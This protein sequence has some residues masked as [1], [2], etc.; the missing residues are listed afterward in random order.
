MI[1][2]K[3]KLKNFKNFTQKEVKLDKL[4]FIRGSNGSGKT[5]IALHSLLFA[6]YGYAVADSLKSL[7]TRNIA[8]S[9]KVEVELD[10]SDHTYKIVR[11]YPTKLIIYEDGKE[12]EFV[13]NTEAQEY[14]NELVGDRINFQKFRIIDAYTKETNFLEEGQTTI[15]RILFNNSDEIFNNIRNKLLQIKHEREIFCKDKAVIYTH[16]PSE[17]RLQ[18]ISSKLD[19]INLQKSKL[20]STIRSIESDAYSITRT[21]G[22]LE[23]E[24]ENLKRKRDKLLENKKCYACN[25]A[26]SESL[27]KGLLTEIG[28]EVKSINTMLQTKLSEQQNLKE[29]IASQKEIKEKLIPKTQKLLDYKVKLEGRLKQKAYKYTEKDILIVKR[30]ISEVDRLSTYYL[31]ESIKILE[32]IINSVLEKI[33]FNVRFTVSDKNKFTITLQKEGIEYK[34]KDLSTGQKLILQIGFKLALLLERGEDGVVIA[35]EGMSSLDEN[36]LN[37][38]IE[39]FKQFPF[40]LLFVLHRMQTKI[41]PIC[42]KKFDE[43]FKKCPECNIDLISLLENIQTIDLDKNEK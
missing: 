34:Y 43:A 5:T 3:I 10:H 23:A 1:I 15:K 9:C 25:Q 22:K 37:H 32:P 33:Q 29:I 14:I 4:V 39:L 6:L 30:A 18:L 16:Y 36:N 13:S 19:K 27:Q 35:D 40:Q 38:I 12:L 28:I 11:Y 17:K 41:C 26:V 21:V 20:D 24:K 31:T 8:K 2:K 7:P 42:N